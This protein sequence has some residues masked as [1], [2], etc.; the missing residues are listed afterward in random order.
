MNA[1]RSLTYG[2][3]TLDI[4]ESSFEKL[5]RDRTVAMISD[6][7]NAVAERIGAKA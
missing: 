3:E 1:S 7:S 5:I 6:I 2:F 4:S